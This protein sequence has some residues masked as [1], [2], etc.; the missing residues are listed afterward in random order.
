MLIEQFK[1]IIKEV[2]INSLR[3]QYLD[4]PLDDYHQPLDVT[5][6]IKYKRRKQ[7]K[8][9]ERRNVV[10]TRSRLVHFNWSYNIITIPKK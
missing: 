9:R 7:N 3:V 1:E 2:G 4:S 10:N 5:T 6:L 8:G